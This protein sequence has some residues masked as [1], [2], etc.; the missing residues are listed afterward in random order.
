M[1]ISRVKPG[2]QR[3]GGREGRKEGGKEGGR[4]PRGRDRGREPGGREGTRAK[5][6]NQL[7]VYKLWCGLYSYNLCNSVQI[8][9]TIFENI[10]LSPCQAT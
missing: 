7:V 4:E 6:G 1:Q 2:N 3:E 8:C 10:L 9:I 5:P